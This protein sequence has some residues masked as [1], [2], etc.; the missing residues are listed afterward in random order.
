MTSTPTPPPRP[1]PHL[2]QL[3][4]II[5]LPLHSSSL[6]CLQLGNLLAHD[7]QGQG[8]VVGLKEGQLGA[9]LAHHL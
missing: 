2:D 8:R 9:L 1:A 6:A 3:G 5:I 7:L 4:R